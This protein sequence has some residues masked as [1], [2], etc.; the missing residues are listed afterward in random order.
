MEFS[1]GSSFT[2]WKICLL[3]GWRAKPHRKHYACKKTKNPKPPVCVWTR[4]DEAFIPLQRLHSLSTNCYHFWRASVAVGF[5][6]LQHLPFK[7]PDIPPHPS[8]KNVLVIY[9]SLSKDRFSSGIFSIRSFNFRT[10]RVN[11]T[12]FL[13]VAILHRTSWSTAPRQA[14]TAIKSR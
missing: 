4:L 6:L 12:F 5:F 7:S 1:K 11:G 13:T 2:D 8:V 9:G 3:C 14:W 10:S